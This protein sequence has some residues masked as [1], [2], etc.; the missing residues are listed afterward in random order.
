MSEETNPKDSA[1]RNKPCMDYIPPMLLLELGL[2]MM[3]GG[4]KYGKGNWRDSRISSSACI[5]AAQRHITS[6]CEGQDLDPGTGNTIHHLTKAIAS[7]AVLRDA[8]MCGTS[9]D[10]RIKPSLDVDA[11]MAR[12]AE[13]SVAI[14]ELYGTKPKNGQ[15]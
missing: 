2:A 14:K 13:A 6:Y 5:N 10:D 9:I 11:E 7:L 4:L 8:I 15:M 3:E 12:L 1:G